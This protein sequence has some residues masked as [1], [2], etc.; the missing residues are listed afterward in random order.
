MSTSIHETCGFIKSRPGLDRPDIQ[1]IGAPFSQVRRPNA[2]VGARF[3]FEP[4]H[5]MNVLGYQMRPESR[6][7]IMI[8]S[9]NPADSP[10][11]QPNY[12]TAEEDCRT[13]VAMVRYVRELFKQAPL[14][15]YLGDETLPGPDVQTDDEI[16]DRAKRI[17]STVF[18]AAGTCK[19]G[20]DS[21]AVVD[22][23]LRVKGVSGLRVVDASVMPTLVSGNTNAAAMVIGWRGA[24]L[25]LQDAART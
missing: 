15:P 22:P 9:A 8:R 18:H 2:G 16:L 6:G 4:W 17:G 19:M 20:Q 25:I 3:E 5:G 10:I 13:H 7:S 1:L 24:E 14:Q 11:I 21:M 12:L 23:A